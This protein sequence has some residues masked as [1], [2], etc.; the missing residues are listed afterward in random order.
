MHRNGT[1]SAPAVSVL[2]PVLEPSELTGLEARISE[3]KAALARSVASYEILVL[4]DGPSK[5]MGP[6]EPQP[7]V[8]T[9]F[10]AY[11]GGR[12]AVL[13]EGYRLSRGAVL[14][15]VERGLDLTVDRLRTILDPIKRGADVVSA[16][17]VAADA[18]VLVKMV[19]R[20]RAWVRGRLD[21]PGG[22]RAYRRYALAAQLGSAHS[23]PASGLSVAAVTV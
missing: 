15:V 9:R 14:V 3:L 23:R 19:A 13:D 4:I 10:R 18:G 12:R 2:V 1:G 6:V 22:L 16:V 17:D 8:R 7:G 5:V 21:R 11:A 20:V